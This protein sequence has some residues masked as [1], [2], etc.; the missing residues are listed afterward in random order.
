M[1]KHR[2]S[3]HSCLQLYICL[4]LVVFK[5]NPFVWGPP[6]VVVSKYV[7]DFEMR[8]HHNTLDALDLIEPVDIFMPYIRP[9]ASRD[10]VVELVSEQVS[11]VAPV[12]DSDH[13]DGLLTLTVSLVN[14][15][16][17]STER[18]IQ[19]ARL[20]RYKCAV[21]SDVIHVIL[22]YCRLCG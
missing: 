3:V 12:V 17:A 9:N 22:C 8:Q 1:Q 18:Q 21:F 19:Y 10:T 11:L 20:F 4:Q 15:T 16:G 13:G 2:D 14:N 6:D 7:V 5:G